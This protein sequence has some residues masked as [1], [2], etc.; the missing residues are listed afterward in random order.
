[1]GTVA[2]PSHANVNLKKLIYT[3]KLRTTAFFL[4]LDTLMI[5][6][7]VIQKGKQTKLL[8]RIFT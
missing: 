8:L 1:M 7:F 3:L 4:T 2:T 6:S 5:Y